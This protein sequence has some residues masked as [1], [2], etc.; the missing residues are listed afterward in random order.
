MGGWSGETGTWVRRRRQGRT[1]AAS[2]VGRR[3]A[4]WQRGDRPEGLEGSEGE[5]EEEE[6]G[7]AEEEEDKD[8]DEEEEEE[9]RRRR[10]KG[11]RWRRRREGRRC[12]RK[13]G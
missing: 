6:E 9:G 13:T 2:L 4:G 1:P 7:D 10:R 3:D 8:E 5:E 12:R 11:R